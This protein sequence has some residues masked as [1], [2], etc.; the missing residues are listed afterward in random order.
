MEK[1]EDVKGN[2][3]GRLVVVEEA[4]RGKYKELRLIC[5]C[6]CGNI[7][8]VSRAHLLGGDVNSC[9]CWRKEFKKT[10]GMSHTRTYQTWENII[11][12]CCN[13]NNDRY[14]DYGG[15]G[16]KVCE[17]WK[18]FENFFADMGERPTG[19]TIDRKDCN[20]DYDPK[21]CCWST[22]KEQQRNRRKN[23]TVQYGGKIKCLAEWAECLG[24][25]CSTLRKRLSRG[26]PVW[27]A[28][29]NG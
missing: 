22:P 28:F 5:K 2:R 14:G 18:A 23:K 15:R 27:R 4:E 25:N 11:D 7:K 20:G 3:F 24:I 26:W 19:K 1:N 13:A 17:R 8:N 6:D 9:G 21:N 12:R 16:I 10:H 29:Q